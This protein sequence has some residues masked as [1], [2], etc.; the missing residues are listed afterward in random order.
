ML[1]VFNEIDINFR[2]E[3]QYCE[4]WGGIFNILP[5]YYVIHVT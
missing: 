4:V 5:M 1:S 3:I 2:T